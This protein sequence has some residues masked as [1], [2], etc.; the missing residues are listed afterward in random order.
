MGTEKDAGYYDDRLAR[1]KYQQHYLLSPYLMLWRFVYIRGVGRLREP[2]VLDLGCGPGQF[3]AMLREL[4]VPK[5]RGLDFSKVAVESGRRVCPEYEFEQRG[6]RT[7]VPQDFAGFN[8]VTCLET[9][10]HIEDDIS[11]LKRIPIGARVVLSVPKHDSE[12]HVRH[13]PRRDQVIERYAPF[14]GSSKLYGAGSQWWV[15][16]GKRK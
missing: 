4:G 9:L 14:V 5:Y 1:K 15:L 11:V 12:S 3:A 10:E 16:V 2:K 6:L 8:V 13:F 7:L